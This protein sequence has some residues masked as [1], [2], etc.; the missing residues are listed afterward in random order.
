MRTAYRFV[1]RPRTFG[2]K[3]VVCHD[4]RWLLVR[5]TYGGHYWTLPGGGVK[6]GEE[7]ADAARREV[8]EEVG[9]RV[10]VVEPIGSYFSTRHFS[11]DTVY[12]F[13]AVTATPVF[14]IDRREIE[15]AAWFEASAIPPSHGAA[16]D[17]VL[18]LLGA[19]R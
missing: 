17:E 2:V 6:R 19:A 8:A 9:I 13:R 14:D 4:G 11:R 16:V 5:N 12:C 18:R 7:P 3:C 15:K 1:R 10:D